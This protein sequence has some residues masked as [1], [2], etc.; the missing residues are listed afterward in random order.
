MPVGKNDV[1]AETELLGVVGTFQFHIHRQFT[2]RKGKRQKTE[3]RN[4]AAAHCH[5]SVVI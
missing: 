5:T 1:S 2:P 3:E 4:H